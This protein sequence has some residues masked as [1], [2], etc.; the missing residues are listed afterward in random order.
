MLFTNLFPSRIVQRV[1]LVC[2]S[3]S[4]WCVLLD[5]CF[6]YTVDTPHPWSPLL[7]LSYTD[8]FSTSLLTLFSSLRVTMSLTEELKQP[9]VFRGCFGLEPYSSIDVWLYHSVLNFRL[10]SAYIQIYFLTSILQHTYKTSY[11]CLLLFS[12]FSLSNILMPFSSDTQQRSFLDHTNGLEALT[13]FCH[14]T[15]TPVRVLLTIEDIL[16]LGVR[17]MHALVALPCLP[18]PC[19]PWRTLH[20]LPAVPLFPCMCL[21][22]NAR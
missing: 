22:L 19:L 15:A 7:L 17:L 1:V 13:S 6:L 12:M 20:L 3:P 11:P 10:I 2:E 4:P 21:T 5:V 18:H 8:S 9:S 14:C 16:C